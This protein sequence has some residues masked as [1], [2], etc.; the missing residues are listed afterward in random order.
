[1][2]CDLHVHTIHSGMCTVP[3]FRR[4]CRESYNQP[5]A[6]YARLKDLGMDL[7]TSTSTPPKP[8]AATPIFS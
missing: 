1:M 5:E 3:G 2:K 6:V 4:I 8:S 7:V